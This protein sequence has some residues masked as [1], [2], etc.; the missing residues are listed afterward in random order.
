MSAQPM[1]STTQLLLGAALLFQ[2]NVYSAPSAAIA[3]EY[4]WTGGQS[5]FSGKIF[6]NAPTSAS[7][8]DGGT[9]ADV[10]PGSYIATPF[11]TFS[12][13]DHGLDAAF[14]FGG[15]M[16]WDASAIQAMDLFFQPAT[17]LINPVYN[18]PA[19]GHTRAD[20]FDN[21]YAIEVGSLAGGFA[22][23]F[24]M[25][26]FSGHWL[27]APAPEPTAAAILALAGGVLVLKRRFNHR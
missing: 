6:L 25:D 24:F 2:A 20:V 17:P 23:A 18:L 1:K 26:D 27:I 11:G 3:Y 4:D 12:I 13:L 7:S 19:I 5:G 16:I 22:T 9:D 21:Q 10:L 8:P 15:L 14:G